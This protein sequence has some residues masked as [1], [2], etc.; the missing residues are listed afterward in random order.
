M[1]NSW[2][3]RAR[4]ELSNSTWVA[5]FALLLLIIFLGDVSTSSWR[6]L[7]PVYAEAILKRPPYFTS[8]LLSVNLVSGAVSALFGGALSDSLGQKRVLLL[9]VSGLPLV[10]LVFLQGSTLVLVLLWAYIGFAFGL[11]TVGRQSYMMAAVPERL[12]GTA[13]ALI[14]LG[15]TL[16]SALGNSLAAPVVDRYGFG[17]LGA[18]MLSLSSGVLLLAALAM[19]EMGG[20]GRR[21][22]SAQSLVGYGAILRRHQVLLLGVLRFVAT[23]YW[24]TASLLMPLL[25]FRSA[26]VPSAAA[27]YGTASLVFASLCQ[28]LSGRVCDRYGVRWPIVILTVLLASI[29]AITSL[30]TTSLPGLFVCGILGAG[31]A[32][33]LSVTIPG[34]VNHISQ[35]E[36]HGR[37][38][39]FTHVAWS[40]GMVVGTQVGG[41]LVE[42]SSGLPFL[43]M[44]LFNV[45]SVASAVMLNRWLS[46]VEKQDTVI[47][48]S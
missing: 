18:G 14:F 3:K 5:P 11:L 10:G 17:V 36:E 19:P 34:L 39:G 30:F 43:V 27:Y 47:P 35:P 29:S 32:W 22:N 6:M 42:V 28:L 4:Q 45:L 15:L 31:I 12:L 38:L 13:T 24:G 44:G 16:G 48:Q 37:T 40:A 41:W 33:S 9:G 23:C 8:M 26:R 25:V 46:R 21:L 2:R 7:L 20:R 1:A